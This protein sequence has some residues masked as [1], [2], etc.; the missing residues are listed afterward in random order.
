MDTNPLRTFRGDTQPNFRY[1]HAVSS[2]MFRF[3]LSE[4]E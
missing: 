1:Q 3:V 2:P 4:L